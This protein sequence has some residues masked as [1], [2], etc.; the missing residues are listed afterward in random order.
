[1]T[2][3]GDY[4]KT[5][6]RCCTSSMFR[7]LRKPRW[8]KTDERAHKGTAVNLPVNW[9][10]GSGSRFAR[11]NTLRAAASVAA[12][13]QFLEDGQLQESWNLAE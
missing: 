4:R 12:R 6:T 10:V 7:H 3:C 2:P 5:E 13:A 9:P 11:A 8:H 1:M